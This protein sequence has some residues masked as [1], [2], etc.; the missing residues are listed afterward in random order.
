[1]GYNTYTGKVIS[2]DP[3]VTVMGADE[4]MLI[5]VDKNVKVGDSVDVRV[6]KD[7]FGVELTLTSVE[8][9]E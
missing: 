6:Y 5:V 3:Y 7:A 9:I 4:S 2:I 1:M 8:I